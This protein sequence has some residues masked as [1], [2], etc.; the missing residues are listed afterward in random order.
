MTRGSIRDNHSD[1]KVK[2]R[3]MDYVKKDDG[4]EYLEVKDGNVLKTIEMDDFERQIKELRK[5][6]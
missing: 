5:N 1:K 4:K 6:A 2:P 3:V